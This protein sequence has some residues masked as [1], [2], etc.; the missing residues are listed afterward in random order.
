LK[1]FSDKQNG[2]GKYTNETENLNIENYLIFY[3]RA[4][5]KATKCGF[6]FGYFALTMMN[7]IKPRGSMYLKRPYFQFKSHLPHIIKY[8][9]QKY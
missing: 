3:C 8:I 7:K 4:L 5:L 2:A 1:Y 9:E 6:N